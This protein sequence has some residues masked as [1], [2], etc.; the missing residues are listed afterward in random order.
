[1]TLRG[2]F[3]QTGKPGANS[4]RFSCRLTVTNSGP[5]PTLWSQPL[6]PAARPGA[7]SR[8]PSGSFTE[9]C[10]PSSELPR[11]RDLAPRAGHRRPA[12]L[13]DLARGGGDAYRC[14]PCVGVPRCALS[15]HEQQRLAPAGRTGRPRERVGAACGLTER[16]PRRLPTAA[17]PGSRGGGLMRAPEEFER[18]LF[19]LRRQTP[20]IG[21]ESHTELALRPGFS[22][23]ARMPPTA[24]TLRHE[25]GGGGYWF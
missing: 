12:G 21:V 14:R 3:T 23:R 1:V 22:A 8:S 7:R 11:S 20:T 6:P 25:A 16:D 18:V 9:R 15:K 13:L 10:L 2:S 24:R 17:P 5:G 19:S 4:L